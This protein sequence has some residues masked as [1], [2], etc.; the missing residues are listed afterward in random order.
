MSWEACLLATVV[1]MLGRTDETLVPR[2]WRTAGVCQVQRERAAGAAWVTREMNHGSE[3]DALRSVR[4]RD[5]A[6]KVGSN[7]IYAS[8]AVLLGGRNDNVEFALTDP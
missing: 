3:Q 4:G 8:P 5:G 2:N 1:R 6:A 7:Q